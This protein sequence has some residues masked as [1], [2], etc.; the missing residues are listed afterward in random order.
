MMTLSYHY[1]N[2]NFWSHKNGRA[3]PNNTKM[4]LITDYFAS[5]ASKSLN[6]KKKNGTAEYVYKMI[7]DKTKIIKAWTKK[8]Y[9]MSILS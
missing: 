8:N 1:M 4:L 9:S 5:A 6:Q 2:T 3:F 7:T